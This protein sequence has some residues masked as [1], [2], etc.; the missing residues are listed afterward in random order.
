M[1]GPQ[2]A[3]PQQTDRLY[4]LL[5]L[6]AGGS[7][8]DDGLVI[9]FPC[10]GLHDSKLLPRHLAQRWVLHGG[11]DGADELREDPVWGQDREGAHG[12]HGRLSDKQTRSVPATAG[13]G[14]RACHVS[15]PGQQAPLLATA[16]SF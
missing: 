10:R 16:C 3:L 12:V 5:S 14:E 15:R 13:M 7:P 6:R 1:C 8:L 9:Q 4:H 2:P 11:G